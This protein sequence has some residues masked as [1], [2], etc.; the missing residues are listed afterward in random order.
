MDIM[1]IDEHSAC[2]CAPHCSCWKKI[3]GLMPGHKEWDVLQIFW[4]SSC[5]QSLSLVREVSC[6]KCS[7]STF[8]HRT[9]AWKANYSLDFY[10]NVIVV[11]PFES[12]LHCVLQWIDV[13]VLL[14]GTGPPRAKVSAISLPRVLAFLSL[15]KLYRSTLFHSWIYHCLCHQI[16]KPHE[17][18]EKSSYCSKVSIV[19]ALLDLLVLFVVLWNLNSTHKPLVLLLAFLSG[20]GFGPLLLNF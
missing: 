17:R 16:Q 4:P 12:K 14:K 19:L 13:Q 15:L 10:K 1:W 7:C 2:V 6:W 9:L 8:L 18:R 20:K 5:F 11:K 3:S